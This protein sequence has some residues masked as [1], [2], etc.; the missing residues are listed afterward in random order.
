MLEKAYVYVMNE[1]QD[2][3]DDIE[4]GCLC[5]MYKDTVPN[6]KIAVSEQAKPEIADTCGFDIW[7]AHLAH[8]YRHEYALERLDDHGEISYWYTLDHSDLPYI[9][10]IRVTAHGMEVRLLTWLSWKYRVRGYA[11]YDYQRFFTNGIPTV[12]SVLMR[13]A[14]EDYEYLYLLNSS[15]LP[16]SS[17]PTDPDE[18]IDQFIVS[19]KSISTD[20][21]A[22][23]NF[24]TDLGLYLEGTSATL[25]TFVPSSPPV[26][27]RDNYYINFQDVAADPSADPLIVDGHTY[28]KCGPTA[29]DSETGMGFYGE[30]IGNDSILL[31]KYSTWPSGFS[32]VQ[33]SFIYDDY[34][35][36]LVFEFDIENGDYLV[37]TSIGYPGY[38]RANDYTSLWINGVKKV[39]DR[40][41][42]SSPDW[43]EEITQTVTVT[44]QRIVVEYGDKSLTQD[45]FTYCFIQYLHIESV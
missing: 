30:N 21:K 4:A 18:L 1:P 17:A 3:A 5:Q 10:P 43:I 32:E 14:F 41:I 23:M 40:T 19:V 20:S 28:I 33:A 13:E 9:N 26:H 12:V 37:T 6:L 8:D 29:Y 24:R 22:F 42:G 35:R 31:M 16:L 15:N 25:P 45:D 7:I 2:D 38:E 27:P 44:H 11:F 36:V 34:G 39:D